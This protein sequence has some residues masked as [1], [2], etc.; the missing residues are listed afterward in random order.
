MCGSNQSRLT[1]RSKTRSGSMNLTTAANLIREQQA[2]LDIQEATIRRMQE[3]M[4]I[5]KEIWLQQ[6]GRSSSVR[7]DP[8]CIPAT[9]DDSHSLINETAKI[10]ADSSRI[11]KADPICE[12]VD[13]DAWNSFSLE[14]SVYLT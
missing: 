4:N 9:R 2:K 7:S 1:T 14:Y 10:I 6:V 12:A 13:E 11:E 3:E 5:A 8:D